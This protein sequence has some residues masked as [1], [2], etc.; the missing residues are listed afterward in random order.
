MQGTA[1]S[2]ARYLKLSRHEPVPSRHRDD[3]AVVPLVPGLAQVGVSEGS[4]DVEM[5]MKISMSLFRYAY[6]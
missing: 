5:E 4:L 1:R 3:K 6:V 2:K